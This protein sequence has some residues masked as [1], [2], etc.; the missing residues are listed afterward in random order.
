MYMHTYVCMYSVC[1][2]PCAEAFAWQVRLG[3]S[4]LASRAEIVVIII[5][6]NS[7]SYKNNNNNNNNSN[8]NNVTRLGAKDCTPEINT[9]E[10]IMDCQWHFPMKFPLCDF[11]CNILPRPVQRWTGLCE[12][13]TG[14]GKD[15]LGQ[16]CI[17]E[18]FLTN[19]SKNSKHKIWH[20]HIYIYIERERDRERESNINI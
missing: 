9:S 18:S 10:I 17:W 13:F 20:G 5:V 2:K 1:R 8:R 11:W 14:D 7:N 6:V 12:D 16:K 4:K 19:R 15:V 3:G